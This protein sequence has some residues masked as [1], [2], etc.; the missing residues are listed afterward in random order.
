[1]TSIIS[2]T[3]HY[4]GWYRIQEAIKQID[5]VIKIID[6]VDIYFVNY[7]V[8][9]IEEPWIGIIHHTSCSFSTN[10]IIS[11]FNNSIFINSLKY[12]KCIISLSQNN[13]FNILTELNKLYSNIPVVVLK[14]PIPPNPKLT[15]F[16]LKHFNDDL[17]VY[18]IGGW[19]RNPYTI[20]NYNFIYE[21]KT[22]RK[23]KLKGNVMDQYFPRDSLDLTTIVKKII[24]NKDIIE[25]DTT[26]VDDIFQYSHPMNSSNYYTK[27]LIE[28]IKILIDKFK[29]SSTIDTDILNILLE[30]HNSVRVVDY[31]ENPEYLDVL[32]SCI[33]FC[34]YIDCSA[35]NTIM[36]CISTA[37]PIILNKL[38]AVVEYLGY[39]YPLYIEDVYDVK[40]NTIVLNEDLLVRASEHLKILRAD[41][42]LTLEYFSHILSII[43]SNI[44]YPNKRKYKYFFYY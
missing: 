8:E 4:Y 30:N 29:N 3:L 37:T 40:T 23:H 28:Y 19:L 9:V 32:E 41:T 11:L 18:N 16:D 12:C 26:N 38:P 36:E 17:N 1:M 20:Y 7:N 42:S 31:L 5:T 6:F 39:D 22:L 15:T 27:Y 14:H 33:V 35:S 44:E 43:C 2:S 34:D 10:N 25:K 24:S 21:G 13:K